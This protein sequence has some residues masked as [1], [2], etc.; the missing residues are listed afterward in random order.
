MLT[1]MKNQLH[2]LI[3][4]YHSIDIDMLK[5]QNKLYPEMCSSLHRYYQAKLKNRYKQKEN[6]KEL[7]QTNGQP[8][9]MHRIIH[10]C[11][12]AVRMV[13]SVI[14]LLNKKIKECLS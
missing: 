12:K 3:P 1:A 13:V 9:P 14:P 5:C 2:F 6:Q 10:N 7:S 4:N 11:R 8:I